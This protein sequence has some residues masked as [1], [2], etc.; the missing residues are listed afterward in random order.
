MGAGF[1][2]AAANRGDG[3][4][5]LGCSVHDNTGVGLKLWSPAQSCVYSCLIYDNGS[6][7]IEFDLYSD[8]LRAIGNTIQGNAGSGIYVHRNPST[9]IVICNNS[10]VSNGAYGIRFNDGHIEAGAHYVDY[11]HYHSNTSGETN[12]TPTPGDNNV[13]GDP[14]FASTTDGSEDFTPGSGSPLL[15]AGL[16]A[17][18]S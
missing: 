12:L 5:F 18:S 13:S 1:N 4:S 10:L 9:S 11:N 14:L 6:H 17:G 8:W 3:V 7:G 2:I 15:A 16:D